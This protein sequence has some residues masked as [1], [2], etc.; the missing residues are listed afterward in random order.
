MSLEM[1]LAAIRCRAILP[2]DHDKNSPLNDL[3]VGRV[4]PFQTGKA[5]QLQTRR[6]KHESN[7]GSRVG[8]LPEFR[9]IRDRETEWRFQTA[10]Q[11][12][13]NAELRYSQPAFLRQDVQPAL[14]NLN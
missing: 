9:T 5:I 6:P 8:L 13:D 3:L 2:Y 11:N 12:E 1:T 4:N 14:W 7:E 10:R